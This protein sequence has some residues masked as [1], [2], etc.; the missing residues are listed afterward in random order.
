MKIKS[1]RSHTSTIWLLVAFGLIP[2]LAAPVMAQQSNE[3]FAFLELFTSEGCSSCPS[4]DKNL[5]RIA[6]TAETNSQNVYTLSWHVD[7]WNRLGWKDP[8]SSDQFTRRQNEY[9]NQFKS[10]RVYTPQLVVNGQIEFVGSKQKESDRAVKLALDLKPNAAIQIKASQQGKKVQVDW[11]AAGLGAGDK[12]NIA[13]VQN[14]GTQKVNR[15]ENANRNLTHVNIVRRFKTI[16]QP[17]ESGTVALE[18]PAGFDSKKF[19]IV[20]FVQSPNSVRAASKSSIG[21][22]KNKVS[23]NVTPAFRKQLIIDELAPTQPN[24]NYVKTGGTEVVKAEQF[25][26]MLRGD[27]IQIRKT[28]AE[29]DRTWDSSYV[30]MILEV[31]RFL[32]PNQR[33]QFFS[34]MESKTGQDLGLDFDSWMQ[35]NWKRD[36]KPHSEYAD[37]KSKLYSIVD[38][39]FSEYFAETA[40]AKIRLDEIRWGGVRRDGIPPLKNPKM[41]E[42]AEATYLA[43]TDVV[44]GIDLNGD[45]R[46]YPKRILAWHEM[47]KDTIGG[48][49]V[50]G[51]Y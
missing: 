37:F 27:R 15:G 14:Q 21:T 32:P 17:S 41:L 13:L 38:P 45:A 2:S 43:D 48:E 49:S 26:E 46:C 50:C 10:D 7:Y 51:V 20:G 44:F 1:H 39:R 31:I 18:V 30:P 12:V 42:A 28:V 5:E 19:H 11:Q 36:Y 25:L 34:L 47:F 29:L 3:G 35:W 9:A 33:L 23:N 40:G 16:K 4:A 6:A 8:Y 24:G 22:T